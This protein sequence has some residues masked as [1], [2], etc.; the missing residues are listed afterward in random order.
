MLGLSEVQLRAAV[1]ISAELN[2]SPVHP[3]LGM[4]ADPAGFCCDQKQQ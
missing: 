1:G 3:G 2:D 4:Q